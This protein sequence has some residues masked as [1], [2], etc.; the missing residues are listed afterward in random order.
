MN[1]G[2]LLLIRPTYLTISP[3]NGAGCASCPL[4]GGAPF[5]GG[6]EGSYDRP[7]T[8]LPGQGARSLQKPKKGDRDA[9]LGM[10]APGGGKKKKKKKKRNH[11]RHRRRNRTKLAGWDFSVRNEIKLFF[12]SVLSYSLFLVTLSLRGSM[13]IRLRRC[14]ISSAPSPPC[15]M[16]STSS[17]SCLGLGKKVRCRYI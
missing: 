17:P 3:H 6:E 11:T 12:F 1:R 10:A 2:P 15:V 14:M 13:V 16:V 5:G 9:C 7:A 4:R 8:V